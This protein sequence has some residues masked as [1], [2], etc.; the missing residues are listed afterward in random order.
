MNWK[1]IAIL[2]LL[3]FVAIFTTQNYEAV[4]IKFLFLAFEANKAIVLILTILT[5][6]LIGWVISVVGR[7]KSRTRIQSV[8]DIFRDEEG[9][10]LPSIKETKRLSQT[11]I[12]RFQGVIDSSTIPIISKN[13]K[14]E[15]K[16]YIDRNILLDFS[17]ATHFDSSTLAYMISLLSQ[18]KKR[19]RK[20]GLINTSS[21]MDNYLDIER[22]RSLVYV[23]KNEKEALKSLKRT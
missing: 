6:I 12:V 13:I 18:M 10:L 20:L 22:V 1:I 8:V 21:E 9:K 5:G 16:V 7:K 15:M 2:I 14:S 4:K 3:L 11:T 23:Y 19:D 17:E